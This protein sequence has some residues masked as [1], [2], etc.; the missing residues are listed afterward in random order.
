[1]NKGDLVREISGRRQVSRAV[2][3]RVVDEILGT[4]S[5][6]L[7]DGQRVALRRFG[8]FH[9][10]TRRARTMRNPRTGEVFRVPAKLLPVFKTSRRLEDAVEKGRART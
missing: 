6:A 10:R 4:I 3:S 9:V 8:A 7:S 5:R 1:M 2:T